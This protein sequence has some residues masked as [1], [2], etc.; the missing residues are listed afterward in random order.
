VSFLRL[1][2]FASA[3]TEHFQAV[4]DRVPDVSP[5]NRL[6]FAAGPVTGGWQV[7]QLWRSRSD[8]EAFNRDVYLPALGELGP[9]AFPVPPRVVD[10]EPSILSL[11]GS[12]P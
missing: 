5:P 10:C 4:A 8:L 2:Y 9:R 1:A 3:T 7:V 6:L 11:T 12:L